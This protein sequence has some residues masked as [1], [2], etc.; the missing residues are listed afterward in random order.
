M[1]AVC[2]KK[3]FFLTHRRCFV[4]FIFTFALSCCGLYPG[5]DNLLIS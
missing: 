5:I 1:A 3:N 4:N 2:Q